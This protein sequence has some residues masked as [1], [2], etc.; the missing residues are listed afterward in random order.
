[1]CS[2]LNHFA[3]KATLF[4]LFSLVSI[5]YGWSG[6][7]NKTNRSINLKIEN[8]R[9]TDIFERLESESSYKFSYGQGVISDQQTY[10]V[11]HR[12]QEFQVVMDDLATKAHL[13][14]NITGQLVMVKKLATPDEEQKSVKTARGPR[15]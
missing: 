8:G 6:T 2:K 14:Y 9:L 4:L 12:N 5:P 3:F 11:D 10:S 1:M 13:S 7:A 15:C